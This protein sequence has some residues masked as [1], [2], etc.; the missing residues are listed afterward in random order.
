MTTKANAGNWPR[1]AKAMPKAKK[2][3][4]H[5]VNSS[6]VLA[7]GHDGHGMIAQY[8]GGKHYNFPGVTA[9]KAEEIRKADSVG[10]ALHAL[11]TKGTAWTPPEGWT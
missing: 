11:G 4:M 5:K 8:K 10:A 2:V 6:H 7:V 3:T 1:K 9:K